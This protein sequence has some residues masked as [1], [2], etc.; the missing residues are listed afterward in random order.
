[1][2]LLLAWFAVGFAITAGRAT[3][4][5]ADAGF[6]FTVE[7]AADR[8][9]VFEVFHESGTGWSAEAVV[10]HDLRGDGAWH[11]LEFPLPA[12]PLRQ[13]RV[14]PG[15]GGATVRIRAATLAVAGGAE[16][17]TWT[18]PPLK[19]VQQIASA[20]T[21]DGVLTIVHA[22]GAEDPILLLDAP[23]FSL[24]QPALHARGWPRWI[25]PLLAALVGLA[26]VH[27]LA[28]AVAGALP[29]ERRRAARWF[30]LGIF[31]AILGLRS[32]W[33]ERFGSPVPYNDEWD[34]E[35][36]VGLIAWQSG[37]L[38]W[39][40]LSAP[41]NEHRLVLSRLVAI[42]TTAVRGEWDPRAGMFVSAALVAALGALAAA[43]V[44]AAAG[45][46]APVVGGAFVVLLGLPTDAANLLW[47]GQTQMYLLLAL[48]FA[49]VA[50]A[51]FPA[52]SRGA[53]L[54]LFT[55]A[56]L[57]LG[58]MG[59]G[60]VAAA[61]AAAVLCLGHRKTKPPAETLRAFAG[62]V[63]ALALIAAAGWFWRAEAPHHA[64]LHA[65]NFGEWWAT[66]LRL[67]A[68]P[69]SGAGAAVLLWLPWLAL[70]AVATARGLR[71]TALARVA[72]ALGVWVLLQTGALAFARAHANTPEPRHVSLLM[73]TPLVG[74]LALAAL[75][76]G[77]R[78]RG[79]RALALGLA[80]GLPLAVA[81][82]AA[83][84]GFRD[85]RETAE[86][87]DGQAAMLRTFFA[88]GDRAVLAPAHGV[89][90]PYQNSVALAG[91][92]EDPALRPLLPVSLR[93]APTSTGGETA[94]GGG[95]SG[96]IVAAL[97]LGLAFAANVPR[98]RRSPAP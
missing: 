36:R 6:L 7:A 82:R 5:A 39:S 80:C 58:S 44:F 63:V 48:A 16:L 56:L 13:L 70:V 19:R 42:G 78:R 68:W 84:T 88:T 43:A 52:R 86:L 4:P 26:L 73:L 41:H 87:R 14:D 40:V 81:W 91:L 2:R 61:L 57:G 54:A 69:W 89:I 46:A 96:L 10:R 51:A 35:A 98:F 32:G 71:T 3:A 97:G 22:P 38:D 33:I 1:M 64:A 27:A 11:R 25:A 9:L 67:L 34:S 65:Q 24:V 74:A 17:K 12:R 31:L 53:I 75:A 79:R 90:A 28:A 50:L 15:W 95:W 29:S 49:V 45:P 59:S 30:A 76:E 60:F 8:D 83:P 18:P 62:A 94:R 66:F 85:L 20:E 72:L 93:A 55:A 21:R 47:G 92:L 23:L 77:E 37:T